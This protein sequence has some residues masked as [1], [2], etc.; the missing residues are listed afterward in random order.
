MKNRQEAPVLLVFLFATGLTFL[1]YLPSLWSGFVYDAEAQILIGDYIH[2]PA[3]F[4]EVV[5][6]QVMGKDVLDFNRPV[7]LF[8][9]MLDSLVWGKRAIGYHLT[10][11]L[12]HALNA[13]MLALLILKLL[14]E[15]T[16]VSGRMIA[17]FAALALAFH[18]VQVEAVAEISSREDVLATFFLLLALLAGEFF[19]RHHGR[20]AV[21]W[22]VLAVLAVLLSCASKET[23]V[24]APVL[25]LILFLLFHRD[26][27]WRPWVYLIV[28]TSA[29]AGIF[30]FARFAL[31]PQDSI[32][33]TREPTWLGGSLSN[34]L[35]IQPRIWLFLFKLIFWPLGLSADYIPQNVNWITLPTALIGL[36]VVLTVQA[37]LAWKSRIATFGALIFWLG[38][39]PVSNFIPMY[40]PLADRF[41]YLP[42]LGMALTLA[43]A[44]SLLK[45]HSPVYKM[46]LALVLAGLISLS[47][48]SVERQKVFSSSLTLWQD[49]VIKSPESFTANSNLAYILREGGDLQ[50]ALPRFQAALKISHYKNPAPFAGLALIYEDLGDKQKAE[51]ALRR[52]ITLDSRYKNPQEL[53]TALVLTRENAES[54][55][56][57]EARLKE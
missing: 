50:A 47:V 39:A 34:T 26:Q 30:L 37:L 9:L 56:K 15:T 16:I 44:L 5:S 42:M 28:T 22:A 51:E 18:P 38:L 14:P 53:V 43:G 45:P 1:L 25:L 48:L 11:N 40:R 23:G 52:A 46:A 24:I 41:L 13:G 3:N 6:F 8:S 7:Q 32:I 17:V 57:I 35:M 2:N 12:L 55:K 31:E 29:V 20:R 19:A 21:G 54:L 4:F 33:F 10:S 27:I 36:L 49:T